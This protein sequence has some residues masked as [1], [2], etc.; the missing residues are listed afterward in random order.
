[1]WDNGQENEHTSSQHRPTIK[2]R[3]RYAKDDLPGLYGQHQFTSG[4]TSD[5]G[6]VA[7]RVWERLLAAVCP[8][9]QKR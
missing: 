1:M 8:G 7:H 6:L 5:G 3:H 2:H 9:P 4:A